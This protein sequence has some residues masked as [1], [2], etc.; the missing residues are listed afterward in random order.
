MGVGQFCTNPG[1]AV[2]IDGAEAD[3]FV[4]AASEAL[5]A[6]APQVMLTTG[7]AEAYRNGVKT[8]GAQNAV[9]EVLGTMCDN[10]DAAPYLYEVSGA[11][12]LANDAL[13]HEVFGPMGMVVRARDLAQMREIALSL[14][15]QLTCTLHMDDG[16]LAEARAF[17][18]ILSAKQVAFW[19]MVSPLGSR[20]AMPWCMAGLILLLQI[21]GRHPWVLWQSAAFCGLSAIKTCLRVCCPV[22]WPSEV[23]SWVC[24]QA[25]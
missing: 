18:P 19:P 15:G 1:I 2:V 7:I 20:S 16:D 8:I 17:L 9:R 24:M 12:W 14:E 4:A 11:D 21:L 23:R 5:A 3:A 13:G 25:R 22:N 10:R 6:T